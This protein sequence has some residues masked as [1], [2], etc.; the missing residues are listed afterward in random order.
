MVVV[1]LH[2]SGPQ[3]RVRAGRLRL[4]AAPAAFAHAGQLFLGRLKLR[5]N[6]GGSKPCETF[7]LQDAT[8]LVDN[9]AV[10]F[11]LQTAADAGRH[12][13]HAINLQLCL[14]RALAGKGVSHR[15]RLQLGHRRRDG[16]V[17]RLLDDGTRCVLALQ[18]A[19]HGQK[20]AQNT[21]IGDPGPELPLLSLHE[22]RR[23]QAFSP[24]SDP[25]FHL[26]GFENWAKRPVEEVAVVG[27]GNSLA[28]SLLPGIPTAETR[29]LALGIDSAREAR[30]TQTLGKTLFGGAAFLRVE[31]ALCLHL[32]PH[33]ATHP[34]IVERVFGPA[35]A[36]QRR[37]H[38]V[39]RPAQLAAECVARQ[40]LNIEKSA[41]RGLL[42]E[43][44]TDAL[45]RFDT[46]PVGELNHVF[47]GQILHPAESGNFPEAASRGLESPL[48]RFT[49]GAPSGRVVA[50][51]RERQ[52]AHQGEGKT[53]HL[54]RIAQTWIR[55][56]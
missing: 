38:L 10:S 31:F 22:R 21:Q 13:A 9:A 25:A 4:R 34:F 28:Y 12:A 30:P 19:L 15:V 41:M 35:I 24:T 18:C 52:G 45:G 43:F 20:R 14:A 47:H 49:L 44:G 23:G 2:K 48:P 7:V 51:P 16:E 26:V 11:G 29:H 8:S 56:V 32:R 36:F 17:A 50:L 37:R 46:L 54:L 33:L 3:I 1:P 55:P 42:D 6:L 5:H 27:K 39:E 53:L 40:H